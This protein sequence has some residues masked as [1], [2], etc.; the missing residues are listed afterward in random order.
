MEGP[1]LVGQ[2]GLRPPFADKQQRH[3]ALQLR[4]LL[5]S[6]IGPTLDDDHLQTFLEAATGATNFSQACNDTRPLHV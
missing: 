3:S 4:S 2:A 1:A 5:R 6:T